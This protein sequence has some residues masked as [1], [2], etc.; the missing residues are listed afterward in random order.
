[1]NLYVSPNGNDAWSGRVADAT[2]ADGPLATIARARDVVREWK[3]SG[4]LAGP[5]TVW[6]RGG[7]YAISEPLTFG[8]EDAGPVTYAAYEGE[9]PVIDGGAIIGGWRVETVNGVSC[10]VADLPDVAAGRLYFRQLFVNGQRRKRA[11]LPKHGYYWMESV[12]GTTFA[13]P[14]FAGANAF[15]AAPGDIQPWR[16]LSDVDVVA[17]HFWIEERMPI[18]AFDPDTRLVT[19][20]RTSMFAL[21]DDVAHRYA[22]Y[23][24]ENVFE[25]LSEPGE[26]Y[27]D[28]AAGKLYY[29][30]WPRQRSSCSGLRVTP[31]MRDTSSI[32]AS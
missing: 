16:N 21:R 31:T 20:S 10:W 18:A 24:V 32:C 30:S 1:M 8:P 26:W 9:K 13:S 28:R 2:G 19:S 4:R 27:L 11:T 25:S 29:V 17:F 15:V 5:V 6:L 3:L 22:R 12:P 14:L 23:I 7:R